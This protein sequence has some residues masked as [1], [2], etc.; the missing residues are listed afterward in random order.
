MKAVNIHVPNG[1]SGE[2]SVSEISI[3]KERAYHANMMM[4]LRGESGVSRV[5][6]GKYKRLMR[7]GV[8]VMSNTPMEIRTHRPFIDKATGGVILLNGL[9][10]GMAASIALQHEAVQRLIIVERSNDV[11]KL[12]GATYAKDKR[13]ELVHADVFEYQPPK[14]LRFDVVWHDIWDDISPDNLAEMGKLLRKYG[15]RTTWQGCWSRPEALRMQA[16]NRREER[17][18]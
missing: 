9:G 12:S 11:L 4:V 5:A 10:L 17:R 3:S 15:R 1:K 13:V 8:V 14:S 7:S 18:W 16:Q 2:W 6:P